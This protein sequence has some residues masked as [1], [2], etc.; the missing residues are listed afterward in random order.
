VSARDRI[1]TAIE[2]RDAEALVREL[3]AHR[4]RALEIL[5]GILEA[6]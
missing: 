5:A 6:G 1:I 4:T 3:D 2:L